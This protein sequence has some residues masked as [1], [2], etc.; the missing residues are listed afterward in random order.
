[1]NAKKGFPICLGGGE[2][3]I[4]PCFMTIAGML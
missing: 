4:V 2:M 1:M 3:T